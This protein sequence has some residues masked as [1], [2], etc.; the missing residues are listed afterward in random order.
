[1]SR[2]LALVAALAPVLAFAAGGPA[3]AQTASYPRSRALN[4]VAAWITTDTPR[5]LSQIVDVGP[6]AVTAVTSS[7]PT[8]EPRGFIV[9]IASEAT[10]PSIG[11]QEDILSWR[12]PVEI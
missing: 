6:S 7:Q 11:K 2:R 3:A 5:Q 12:I 9:S 4:D 1:M 8:G 10:D